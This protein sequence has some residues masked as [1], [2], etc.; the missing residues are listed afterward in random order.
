MSRV[1]HWPRFSGGRGP[2]LRAARGCFLA[3]RASICDLLVHVAN[4]QSTRRAAVTNKRWVR[5]EAALP[6]VWCDHAAAGSVGRLL[7]QLANLR[8]GRVIATTSSEK[9]ARLALT[10]AEGGQRTQHAG[11]HADEDEP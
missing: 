8:R 3:L 2:R 5:R 6:G 1:R 9:E 10:Y 7:A 11:R 4:V